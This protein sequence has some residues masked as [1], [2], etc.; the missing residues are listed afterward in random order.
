MLISCSHGQELN[1]GQVRFLIMGY[2]SI[3]KVVSM[4]FTLRIVARKRRLLTRT[5]IDKSG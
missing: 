2:A 1:E 5:L 4:A 3:Y